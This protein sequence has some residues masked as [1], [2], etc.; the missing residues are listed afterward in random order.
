V[1]AKADASPTLRDWAFAA[2]E[3][4]GVQEACL[5]LQDRHEMDVV[6]LLWCVWVGE[7][8]GSVEAE[9]MGRVVGEIAGW[10]AEVVAP[11]RAVR[12]R[13]KQADA[14]A[15]SGGGESAVAAATV[16]PDTKDCLRSQVA[17]AE[18]SAEVI[19][20]DRLESSTLAGSEVQ[21]TA[22]A[23]VVAGPPGEAA[24]RANLSCLIALGGPVPVPDPG[25]GAAVEALLAALAGSGS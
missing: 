13:L 3:R 24:V 19:Q 2:Y 17:D 8:H 16:T 18:L 23:S 10:Q 1:T 22:G 7:H 14:A 12:R 15:L 9:V 4:P 20:L 21:E 6:A 5:E 25:L 11:L